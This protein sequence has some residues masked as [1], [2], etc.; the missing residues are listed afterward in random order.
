MT[1]A[2]ISTA[3]TNSG[4]CTYLVIRHFGHQYK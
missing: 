1:I 2:S 4:A 3:I